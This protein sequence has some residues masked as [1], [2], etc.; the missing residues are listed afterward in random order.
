MTRLSMTSDIDRIGQDMARED[1]VMRAEKEKL[2]RGGMTFAEL[3]AAFGI[4]ERKLRQLCTS[5]IHYVDIR[6]AIELEIKACNW[7]DY[8]GE[9]TALARALY[10]ER[11]A[12]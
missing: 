7:R 11:G 4:N 10:D 5:S 8:V 12:G 2:E 9:L 1:A 6:D 3:C